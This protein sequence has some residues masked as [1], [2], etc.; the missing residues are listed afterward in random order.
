MFYRGTFSSRNQETLVE[1]EKRASEEQEKSVEL[2]EAMQ[3]LEEYLRELATE[4]EAAARFAREQ[5]I[6]S[7]LA[8][9]MV[10]RRIRYTY[11]G[12]Q[13]MLSDCIMAI[14]F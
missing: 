13:H 5:G 11:E 6:A 1:A 12:K 3:K 14:R 8:R 9:R 10:H 2:N 7:T 4:K